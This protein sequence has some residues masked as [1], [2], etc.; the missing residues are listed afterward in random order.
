MSM[1]FRR[2]HL[3]LGHGAALGTQLHLDADQLLLQLVLLR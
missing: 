3:P 2:L 1:H